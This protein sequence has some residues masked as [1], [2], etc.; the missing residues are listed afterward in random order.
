MNSLN[1]VLLHFWGHRIRKH[2]VAKGI[3]PENSCLV[4]PIYRWFAVRINSPVLLPS[5][6]LLKPRVWTQVHYSVVIPYLRE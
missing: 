6:G 3:A 4:R 2:W 1:Q 5:I